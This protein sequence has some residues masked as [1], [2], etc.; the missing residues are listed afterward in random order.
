MLGNVFY[1]ILPSG[2]QSVNGNDYVNF[3]IFGTIY[4]VFV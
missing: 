3:Q 4:K 1:E 2:T